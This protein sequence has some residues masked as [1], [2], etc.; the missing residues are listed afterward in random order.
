MSTAGRKYVTGTRTA[1]PRTIDPQ[2]AE[3]AEIFRTYWQRALTN[4]RYVALR[5]GHE[6]H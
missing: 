4:R 5:R 1:R 3:A 6:G 2:K